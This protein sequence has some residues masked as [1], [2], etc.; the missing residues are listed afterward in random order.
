MR[1]PISPTGAPIILVTV[2]AGLTMYWRMSRQ[3]TLFGRVLPAK[4]KYYVYENP[5]DKYQKFIEAFFSQY[6]RGV[7]IYFK[8]ENVL[9]EAQVST[10]I[11]CGLYSFQTIF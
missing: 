11:I 4:K 2:A 3:T 8:Q 7:A 9:R 6:C 1:L 5:T 10:S